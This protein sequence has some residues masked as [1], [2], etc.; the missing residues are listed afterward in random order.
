VHRRTRRI[1]LVLAI[2]GLTTSWL[3][4]GATHNMDQ[5]SANMTHLFSSPNGRDQVNSDQAF[6]GNYAYQG[7]Y[8]G[9]R[10]F[11]ISNPA[12]PTLVG[13]MACLGAQNDI[14]VWDRDGNGQADIAFT[15]IDRTQ[16]GPNC[17]STNT[18]HD[19]PAGW[20]G[21]R[22]FDVSNPASP[23]QIGSVY[24][25]CGS[26]TNTLWPDPDNN[27]VLLYNSSYPLRPGPTCG[28]VRGPA[29]GRDP[30]HGVIQVVEVSWSP[31]SPL[32]PVTAVEIAEP[33][34]N[35]PGDPDNKFTPSEHGLGPA[36][37]P[38]LVQGMRACHDISVYVPLRLAA[39]AC[40]E[41]AQLWRVKPNGLPD[42]EH[43]IWVY[44]DT[45]D[46][47][48]TTGSITDKGIVVD[49]WHSA[50]FSWDGKIVH[51]EDESFSSGSC[52]PTTPAP[53][54]SATQPGDTGRMFF[55]DTWTGN[56][57][58]TYMAPMPWETEYCSAHLGNVVPAPDKKLLAFGW[59]MGGAT[60]IDFTD[61]ANPTS[62]AHYDSAGPTGPAGDDSSDNWTIYWY[63]GPSLPGNSLTLY[64][65]DGVHDP[66]TGDGGARGFVTFRADVAANEV[67]LGYLNPQTQEQ[68]V[69]AVRCKGKT[70]TIV[71][72]PGNDNIKGTNGKDVIAALGGND[73]VNG[74]K[75][76]DR[77]CGAKG[78]DRL[79]GAG[80]KDKL[81]GQ[82][83]ND[84][85]NGGPARDFCHGGPGRDRATACEKVKS[86]P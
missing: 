46:E 58:S 55:F 9:F 4:A 84:R 38:T 72:S 2:V 35:Y 44:D 52:P 37:D 14:T 43:P 71:G 42:T 29:V 23:T 78:K 48:G 31:S 30:L 45:V 41:Q 60:V 80:G 83:S 65:T 7:D 21:L 1:L 12:S 74:S 50:T 70:A 69:P 5:H 62:V 16:T 18:A 75:G 24:L 34:I 61:P 19:N 66:T 28:P 73:R 57:R 54:E 81:Y 53:G 11:N 39:A 33:K 59:Y 82:G 67:N 13:N 79:K 49:F 8:G 3:P 32:G 10:I 64:G 51:F 20:E 56:L 77:I 86:I 76:N 68:L 26:H 36:T 22:I 85:L 63:E 25:D 17:G 27:R 40:A 15:S 6:W 47:T